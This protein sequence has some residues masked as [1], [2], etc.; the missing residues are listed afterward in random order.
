[1]YGFK[2]IYTHAIILGCTLPL[3]ALG[4][5]NNALGNPNN[6][7]G[8]PNNAL[9]NPNNALGNPNNAL[10]NP[11]NALGNPN[12]CFVADD[13]LSVGSQPAPGA[14]WQSTCVCQMHQAMDS[15]VSGRTGGRT[16]SLLF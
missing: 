11:N 5:P 1:M 2:E 16:V 10:G 3:N 15:D 4:N 9:G 8:N 14:A 12:N 13:N 6:A 7:L